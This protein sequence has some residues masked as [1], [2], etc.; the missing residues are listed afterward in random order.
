MSLSSL[1]MKNQ[2]K[3]WSLENR[4]NN[5]KLGHFWTQWNNVRQDTS[6]ITQ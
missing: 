5:I 2:N 3:L 4:K 6:N 1:V